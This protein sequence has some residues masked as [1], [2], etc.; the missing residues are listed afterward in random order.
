M[1]FPNVS[2]IVATTIESRTGEIADNAKQRLCL[3]GKM[4]WCRWHQLELRRCNANTDWYRHTCSRGAGHSAASLSQ[5]ASSGSRGD[6]AAKTDIDLW[7]DEATSPDG[8][9]SRKYIQ[10]RRQ[11]NLRIER[12]RSAHDGYGGKCFCFALVH[13]QHVRRRRQHCPG[14]TEHGMGFSCPW[15]GS[16]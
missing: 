10:G 15:H 6:V 12:S 11:N 2:D 13:Q 1:A 3:D 4:G 8:I 5:A 16:P 7:T 14:C 9:S